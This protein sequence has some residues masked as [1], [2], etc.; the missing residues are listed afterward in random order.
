[1]INRAYLLTEFSLKEIFT[2]DNMYA[3]VYRVKPLWII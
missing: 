3:S 1:M 2:N